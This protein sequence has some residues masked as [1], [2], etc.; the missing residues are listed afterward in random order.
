M[1]SLVA[2]QLCGLS[3]AL[4]SFKNLSPVF[5]FCL[6][7]YKEH[8]DVLLIWDLLE[9]PCINPSSFYAIQLPVTPRQ[10]QLALPCSSSLLAFPEMIC[11][12]P[13][14]IEVK[15]SQELELIRGKIYES[16]QAFKRIRLSP[17]LNYQSFHSLFLL[18]IS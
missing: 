10:N 9:F 11:L 16:S 12:I 2:V 6:S 3:C 13:R 15:N 7:S 8:P 4:I 14:L 18:L 17:S 5:P 1:L